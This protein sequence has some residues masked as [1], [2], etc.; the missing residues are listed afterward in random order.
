MKIS[1]KIIMMLVLSLTMLT[2]SLGFATFYFTND[3]TTYFTKTYKENLIREKKEELKNEIRIVNHFLNTIYS[4]GKS[5]GLSDKE[6]EKNIYKY[7]RNLRFFNDNSGY[8]FMYKTNG[9]LTFNATSPHLEGKNL[10]KLKN[11]DNVYIVKDLIQKAQNGGGFLMFDWVKGKDRVMTPKIGYATMFKPLNLM[12]GTGVY[13]DNVDKDV[14]GLKAKTDKQEKENILKFIFLAFISTI[15]FLLI[16]I[17]YTKI[18]II[19]P[20]L[21]LIDKAK[22]LS[23]GDG[24]LTKILSIKSKDEIGEAS[25]AI[26]DF[27]KKVHILV[28]EAKSL[29]RKNSSIAEELS[30][31]SSKTGQRTDETTSIITKT[32][33][34]ADSINANMKQYAKEAQS[35][36]NNAKDTSETLDDINEFIVDLTNK[37]EE[38][39]ATEMELAEKISQLSNDADQVK[40]ILSVINDIA[41][42]TNLL[43]LN[44]AIE[45][46]RAGEHGRGFAVV[47]DEVRKLAERTQKSLVE[48]NATINVIVQ[49]INDSSE[50][51][52]ANSKDIEKLSSLAALTREKITQTNQKMHNTLGKTDKIVENYLTS[53]KNVGKIINDVSNIDEIAKKNA[54]SVDEIANRAEN[55]NKIAH[56][57]NEKLSQFKT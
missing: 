5:Q 32:A 33:K 14:L 35:T 36:K 56:T 26:N 34:Q 57:L 51:M 3:L 50:K 1:G 31:I 25:S 27:I 41:D 44:A 20:L 13:I 4:E 43:A 24:D 48:I 39:S 49:A 53:E 6:V 40:D 19:K 45:A 2:I 17:F 12:I 37:I 30:T 9:V 15:I 54:K 55:L 47:A 11:K 22:D 46:A 29:S 16:N 7:L 28:G 52:T 23:S 8:V 38:S 18:N 21:N 42:Q 10:I